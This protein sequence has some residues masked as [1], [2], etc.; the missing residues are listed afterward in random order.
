MTRVRDLT[1]RDIL[2]L[3]LA[4]L[5]AEEA[6]VNAALVERRILAETGVDLGRFR[7]SFS[8]EEVHRSPPS[9][10]RTDADADE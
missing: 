2:E 6:R 1:D 5:R 8:L 7:V 9:T 3:R 4:A 10:R